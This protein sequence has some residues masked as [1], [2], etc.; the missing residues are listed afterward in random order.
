[1]GACQA[2]GLADARVRPSARPP[3]TPTGQR[4]RGVGG[5]GGALVRQLLR[6]CCRRANSSRHAAAGRLDRAA[7]GVAR[8]HEALALPALLGRGGRSCV[9]GRGNDAGSALGLLGGADDGRRRGVAWASNGRATGACVRSAGVGGAARRTAGLA[10]PATPTPRTHTAHPGRRRQRARSRPATRR[11]RRPPVTRAAPRRSA[12]RPRRPPSAPAAAPAAPSRPRATP[13]PPPRSP[14]YGGHS[15]HAASAAA[16]RPGCCMQPRCAAQR[17]RSRP[18]HELLRRVPPCVRQRLSSIL[19]AAAHQRRGR[20]HASLDLR[21]RLSSAGRQASRRAGLLLCLLVSAA[22][23][24]AVAGSGLSTAIP[25]PHLLDSRHDLLVHHLRR[26]AAHVH[27][28]QGRARRRRLRSGTQRGT[29]VR[30]YTTRGEARPAYARQ[31]A[32]RWHARRAA[33]APALRR[34]APGTAARRAALAA[35]R[36]RRGG[37]SSPGATAGRRP[38]RARGGGGSGSGS[39]G[40]RPGRRPRFALRRPP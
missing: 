15:T 6:L 24:R 3:S 17:R 29:A 32:L 18:H 12:P 13:C 37:S 23:A 9:S 22:R 36:G 31:R 28:R 20:A 40:V 16:V 25:S 11:P 1:M 39:G 27:A 14:V 34:L 33:S 2:G 21:R 19:Q 26:A 4:A 5:C 38:G 35:G 10:A 7:C 30:P 8:R